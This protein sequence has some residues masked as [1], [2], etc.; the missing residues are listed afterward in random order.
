MLLQDL[1]VIGCR[2]L[3]YGKLY[4]YRGT[5][6]RVQITSQG[7]ESGSSRHLPGHLQPLT[8]YRAV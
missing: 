4:K 7:V 5:E 2:V 3:N 1:T 8:A 6:Y